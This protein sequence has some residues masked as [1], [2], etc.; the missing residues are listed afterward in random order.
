MVLGDPSLAELKFAALIHDGQVY[1]QEVVLHEL[2]IHSANVLFM[3]LT[4]RFR[5][6]SGMTQILARRFVCV[7]MSVCVCVS[8]CLCVCCV[9]VWGAV[10]TW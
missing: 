7:C 9:C 3:T 8:V 1:A 10:E 5:T 4:P 2:L 6:G